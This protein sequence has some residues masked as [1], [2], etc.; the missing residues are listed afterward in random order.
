MQ[1][2]NLGWILLGRVLHSLS[3][4]VI[5]D[6]HMVADCLINVTHLND[7]VQCHECC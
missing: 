2:V 1:S 3:A 5:N 7:E 6:V 4:C